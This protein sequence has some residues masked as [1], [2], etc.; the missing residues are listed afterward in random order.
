MICTGALLAG[1]LQAHF[2]QTDEDAIVT[3]RDELCLHLPSMLTQL[4]AW[5][6]A[7][8]QRHLRRLIPRLEPL[9]ELGRFHTLLPA[10]LADRVVVA[11]C[12]LPRFEQLYRAARIDEASSGLRA[13]LGE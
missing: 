1:I 8:A 4:P 9:L 11:Q 3:P 6:A 10:E 7:Q 2:A 12:D 13:L 5:K